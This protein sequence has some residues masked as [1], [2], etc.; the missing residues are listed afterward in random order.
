MAN[1]NEHLSTVWNWVRGKDDPQDC[2]V[3]LTCRLRQRQS[4]K[5]KDQNLPLTELQAQPLESVSHFTDSEA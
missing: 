4:M 5:I 1:G 3:L 2:A